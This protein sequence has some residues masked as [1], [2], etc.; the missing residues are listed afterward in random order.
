MNISTTRTTEVIGIW[1]WL[2]YFQWMV[3]IEVGKSEA[4]AAIT[5]TIIIYVIVCGIFI[6]LSILWRYSCRGT[7]GPRWLNSWTL[8]ARARWATCRSATRLGQIVPEAIYQKQGD[9]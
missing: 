9:G 8:S 6:A 4:F 7:S 5:K 3:L 2:S 1:K